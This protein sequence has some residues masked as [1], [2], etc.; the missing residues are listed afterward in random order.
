[1]KD[2]TDVS[3]DVK[4]TKQDEMRFEIL[5]RDLVMRGAS[6]HERETSE[7]KRSYT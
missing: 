3:E 7:S 5:L 1:M 4:E 2:A 6:E